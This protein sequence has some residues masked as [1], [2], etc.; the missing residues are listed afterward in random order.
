MTRAIY[1]ESSALV[2]LLIEG[3]A[4][5]GA[6]LAGAPS[7]TASAL[8][9]LETA[10]AIS[11]KRRDRSLSLAEARAAERRLALFERRLDVLDITADVLRVARQELP[12][13]PVRSL[14]AIH[15][16]SI[17]LIDE[18][19]PGGLDVASCDERVRDNASALGFRVVP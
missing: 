18:E 11:R 12:V 9:M 10:R 8:T 16:A 15:L 6:Q 14:D 19:E 1:V 4:A 7:R 5:L 17:R 13:E 3:D 2:R